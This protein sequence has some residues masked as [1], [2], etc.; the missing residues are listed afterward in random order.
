MLEWL[1]DLPETW[2]TGLF[3]SLQE[4][5]SQPQNILMDALFDDPWTNAYRSELIYWYYP[6]ILHSSL[7]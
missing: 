5:K 2:G 6:D 3:F 4:V 1:L 7:M